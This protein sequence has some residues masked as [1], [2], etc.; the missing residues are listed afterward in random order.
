MKV[1]DLKEVK[2]KDSEYIKSLFLLEKI[3]ITHSYC[4]MSIHI[5][6]RNTIHLFNNTLLQ[7]HH[8][9]TTFLKEERKKD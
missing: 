1:I 8:K 9:K 3:I 5:T 2:N 6:L 7:T 4:P